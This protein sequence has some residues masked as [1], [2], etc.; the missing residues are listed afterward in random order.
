MLLRH[1]GAERVFKLAPAALWLIMYE[2]LQ[3]FINSNTCWKHD[4]VSNR[5]K[6]IK[7]RVQACFNSLAWLTGNSQSEGSETFPLIEYL[8]PSPG[9]T[10]GHGAFGKV[11]EASAFGIDKMSTCKTVAVKMLKGGKWKMIYFTFIDAN[12]AVHTGFLF[13]NLVIMGLKR[14]NRF[15]WTCSTTQRATGHADGTQGWVFVKEWVSSW[16]WLEQISSSHLDSPQF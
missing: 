9:K 5:L 11:V 6:N 10:L 13:C 1:T 14:R 4:D 8:F 12:F 3:Q 16:A 7:I 2:I 15:G